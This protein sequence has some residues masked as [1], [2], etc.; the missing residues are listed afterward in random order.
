MLL[1]QAEP[2]EVTEVAQAFSEGCLADSR[3]PLAERIRNLCHPNAAAH[4]HLEQDLEP[5]RPKHAGINT[6]PPYEKESAHRV[7]HRREPARKQQLREH[8][9]TAGYEAA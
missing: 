9:G 7:T 8:G 1:A 3:D 5:V 6:V 2:N 4:Q